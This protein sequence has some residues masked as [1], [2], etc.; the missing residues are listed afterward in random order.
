MTLPFR[1]VYNFRP[2]GIVPFLPLKPTQTYYKTYQYAGWLFPLMKVIA[3]NLVVDLKDLAAAMINASLRGYS[4]HVL[5]V[6]DIKKL[7]RP[8]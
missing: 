6:K 3:P 7:A 5:E 4:K 1:Q 8:N 2:P